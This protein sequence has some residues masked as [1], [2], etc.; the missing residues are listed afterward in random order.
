MEL[1]NYEFNAHGVEMGQFYT[2]SAVLSDGSS[3]P[4]PTR[5]PELYY[6]ASTVPGSPLPHVWVGDSLH[7]HSTL[8]LA[9]STRFTIF[10]GIAGSEWAEVAP[11][12]GA[13]LGIDLGAVVIGPGQD[14]T[15]LYFD[16]AKVREVG[17]DGAIL[18]RPDK[19]IAWRSMAMVADPEAALVAALESVLSRSSRG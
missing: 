10:T 17:E 14:V 11:R 13:R 12:V 4:E 3:K 6:E 7:K 1:K 18:V 19:I 8:D 5:D 16:W 2:S 15:D 9:P